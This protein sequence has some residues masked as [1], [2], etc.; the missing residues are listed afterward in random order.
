M[1]P[2]ESTTATMTKPAMQSMKVENPTKTTI[3]LRMKLSFAISGEK[4]D[5]MVEFSAF[6]PS[7]WV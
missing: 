6:E 1:F 5:E 3:R 7:L 4:V 2:P